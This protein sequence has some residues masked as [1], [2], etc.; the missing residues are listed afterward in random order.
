MT[1]IKLCSRK[2][3]IPKQKKIDQELRSID[4]FEL[5]IKRHSMYIYSQRFPNVPPPK[6]RRS[7]GTTVV[8]TPEAVVVLVVY[9]LPIDLGKDYDLRSLYLKKKVQIFFFKK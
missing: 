2:D 7:L 8:T 4:L 9:Y 5:S 3:I 6:S 1:K